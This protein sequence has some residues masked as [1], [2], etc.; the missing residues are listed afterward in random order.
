M[1]VYDPDAGPDP[2]AWL[3]LDE[4]ERRALV[5][6]AHPEE[7]GIHLSMH[8][9]VENQVASGM[10]AAA[11]ETV[12]RFVQQGMRRH[13]AIHAVASVLTAHLSRIEHGFDPV[14]YARDLR[15]LDA[16]TWIAARIRQDLG[17]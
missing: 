7:T 3:A 6:A 1:D 9:V 11:A 12:A 4:E 14:A 15:A 10:P 5:A 16:A 13:Q 2:Q 17:G 8:V